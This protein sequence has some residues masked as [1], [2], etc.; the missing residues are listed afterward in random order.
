[1]MTLLALF[2]VLAEAESAHERLLAQPRQLTN[3]Q[4]SVNCDFPLQ[5]P[6]DCN[7]THGCADGTAA[8]TELDEFLLCATPY[9]ESLND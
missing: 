7:A 3:L 1:M 5:Y 6:D 2:A 9:I 8:K 4:L